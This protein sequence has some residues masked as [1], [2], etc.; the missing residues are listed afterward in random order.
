M[1]S[2]TQITLTDS[3]NNAVVKVV[4]QIEECDGRFSDR[5]PT[6]DANLVRCPCKMLAPMRTSGIKDLDDVA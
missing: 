3:K 5:R 6:H 4:V 2:F 1:E